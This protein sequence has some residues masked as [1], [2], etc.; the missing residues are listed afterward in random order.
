MMLH[1]ALP[2]ANRACCYSEDDFYTARSDLSS[3]PDS[4]PD[5]RIA[6]LTRR[7]RH[8]TSG[9]FSAVSLTQWG[10]QPAQPNAFVF[11]RSFDW[12]SVLFSIMIAMI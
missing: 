2:P 12:Q 11:F 1:L 7:L 9:L 5:R 6:G 4:E 10:R 3:E 8:P